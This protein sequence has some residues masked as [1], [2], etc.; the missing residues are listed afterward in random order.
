MPEL[1]RLAKLRNGDVM[2][3]ACKATVTQ[4]LLLAKIEAL[5]LLYD[6]PIDQEKQSA[7]KAKTLI[8]QNV[9]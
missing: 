3:K 6:L 2:A 8:N 9:M 7:P 5:T 1:H 4:N